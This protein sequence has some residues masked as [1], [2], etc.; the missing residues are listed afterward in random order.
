V[1][2][3]PNMTF[4]PQ[5]PEI[6]D[7]GIYLRADGSWGPQE[8]SRWPQLDTTE[9]CHHN[10]IPCQPLSETELFA[11]SVLWRTF[12]REDWIKLPDIEASMFGVGLLRSD[13]HSLLVQEAELLINGVLK[14]HR[15]DPKPM[16][17]VARITAAQIRDGLE[18]LK[19]LPTI[20]RDTIALVREVQR[21]VLELHGFSN[22]IKI[23]MPRIIDTEFV[24]ASPLHY[25]GAFTF[26]GPQ[27]QLLH[28]VGIPVW[29]IRPY[30]AV[31][32]DTV[33]Y[34]AAE[35]IKWTTIMES[36]EWILDNGQVLRSRVVDGSKLRGER[37]S[38]AAMA[39]MIL[40]MHRFTRSNFV[41]CDI[42]PSTGNP[43]PPPAAPGSSRSRSPGP[44]RPSKRFRKSDGTPAPKRGQSEARMPMSNVHKPPTGLQGKPD[45]LSLPL[46]W[47]SAILEASPVAV[48]DPPVKA[49][50]YFPPPWLLIHKDD[51]K[52]SR[53]YHNFVRVCDF[54]RFRVRQGQPPLS[55]QNWRDVLFGDYSR[56][57]ELAED[58]NH[59]GP[60][61]EVAQSKKLLRQTCAEVRIAFNCKGNLPNY[62]E[63]MIPRWRGMEITIQHAKTDRN[64]REAVQW[65][66]SQLNWRCELK[67]L[68][69]LLLSRLAW[70]PERSF[71]RDMVIAN[72]WGGHGSMYLFPD[73]KT[74]NIWDY[75]NDWKTCRAPVAAFVNVLREWPDCPAKLT[76]IVLQ[77][78]SQATFHLAFKLCT[79]F[80]VSTFIRA[81]H[82][83]PTIPTEVPKSLLL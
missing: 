61:D 12:S 6:D 9:I 23:I 57:P 15:N 31:T 50:Y 71:E 8:F 83:L 25:R 42:A 65:E 28:R 49:L 22:Y 34:Q 73:P 27:A 41:S 14:D 35:T 26:D 19:R 46:T 54:C 72:V 69:H 59:P 11:S 66:L 47:L 58:L 39:K 44:S 64:L 53:N 78:C 33:I 82:R 62:T 17:Q 5:F 21:L 1:I 20:A 67:A 55:I 4:I 37:Q 76:E 7:Q 30:A 75:S 2:T 68:D 16:W 13:L 51:H 60:A 74:S 29:L 10:A 80:Y 45:A 3:S 70:E 24:A 63:D 56:V 77:D 79:K 36:G 52:T 48:P 81:Y 32:L 38:D 18:S 40:A 43:Q